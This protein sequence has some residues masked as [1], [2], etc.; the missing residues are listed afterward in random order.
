MTWIDLGDPVPRSKPKQY[1][2]YK[3]Q[4]GESI[5]LPDPHPETSITADFFATLKRRKSCREF[6]P[7]RQDQ[8]STFL[9]HS[10]SSREAIPSEMGFD[11][12]RRPA[13]SAGAIHPIHLLLQLPSDP[14][15]WRYE[16]KHHLLIEVLEAEVKL[17]GLS[18]QS[19]HVLSSEYAVRLLLAAEIAK[20]SSKYHNACSLVWRDAGVLIGIMSLTA[21]ALSLSFCPLGITGE[22]WVRQLDVR[23]QLAGVGVALL[24]NS[25][26]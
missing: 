25:F 10:A 26:A 9:W 18:T 8:L 16:P 24:G 13:P 12:E 7:L 3:W 23:D 22:P 5:N 21:Q 15:W 19:Q 4:N 1:D 14:R 20:V 11:L 6:A 2:L 17:E